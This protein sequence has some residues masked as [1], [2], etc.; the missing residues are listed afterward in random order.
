MRPADPF[1]SRVV[2]TVE[3]LT[4]I[5][6]T[7]NRDPDGDGALPTL[8]AGTIACDVWEGGNPTFV[9]LHPRDAFNLATDLLAAVRATTPPFLGAAAETRRAAH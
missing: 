9:T 4:T 5:A 6:V 1:R 8:P 3:E 2:G 7:L